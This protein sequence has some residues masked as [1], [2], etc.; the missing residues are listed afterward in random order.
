[1]FPVQYL[2]RVLDVPPTPDSPGRPLSGLVGVQPVL[3]ATQRDQ[4]GPRAAFE[5]LTIGQA[6]TGLVKSTAKG[7]TMV[8]VEGQTVAM[9]LP[10]AAAPGDTLRLRFAGHM[11]QAVFL[12]APPESAA[13][14]APQLSQTARMLSD[15]MQQLP[16]RSALPTL[17]PPGPLLDQVTTN[18]ALIALALRT[19]LVRSGLFYESHLANWVGGQDSLDGLMQEPQ[20]KLAAAE[21]ARAAANPLALLNAAEAAPKP[22]NPMHALLTQQL[23][24]LESP[25]LVWRGEVWPGQVLEWHLRHETEHAQ[26][27]SAAMPGDEADAGWESTLKLSLPQLGTVTAHIKLDA[28]QAFS[29]RLVPEQAEV[30]PLLRQNQSRLMEQLAAAGCTLQT[31][32]VRQDDAAD[33]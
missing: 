24:V 3:N 15:L 22:L 6:L 8:E 32:A 23:Q 27:Q 29:I 4:A 9:R 14:D 10:H 19:A 28:N 7:I 17:T 30:E 16:G 20:N 11:P 12:L 5:Q 33:A 1:M 26:N 2:A 31:L 13:R 18:P 25:Q 21:A